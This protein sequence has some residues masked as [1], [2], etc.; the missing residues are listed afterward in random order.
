MD[1]WREAEIASDRSIRGGQI[2]SS[3]GTSQP[4]S[5]GR[6][7]DPPG[8]DPR[9]DHDPATKPLSPPGDVRD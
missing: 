7:A 8:D 4:E 3:H 6:D 1:K 9:R 5:T 2:Q